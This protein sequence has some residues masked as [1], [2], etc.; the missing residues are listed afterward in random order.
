MSGSP[1]DG[2]GG[3]FLTLLGLAL[4]VALAMIF[5]PIVLVGFPAYVG[6]RLYKESPMRLERLAREVTT[7]LYDY[8]RAGTVR[9]TNAEIDAALARHWP[10]DLPPLM[11]IQLLQ[12][13]K[14]LF[15][16][17][18]WIPDIPPLPALCNTVESARY[19]DMLAR[20]SQARCDRV[21]VMSALEGVS[22]SLAPIANAVLP[23]V[24]DVLVEVTQFVHPL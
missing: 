5:T 20:A 10:P 21:M 3:L 14:A 1:A 12:V 24:G 8:A 16:Q 18:G 19:R 4:F 22:Q 15:A 6:Y 17:K 23:I 2:F 7:V 9:L 13:G 11:R